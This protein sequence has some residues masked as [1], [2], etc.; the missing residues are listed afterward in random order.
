MLDKVFISGHPISP[1]IH[2]KS[3]RNEKH[4]EHHRHPHV[5]RQQKEGEMI[6]KKTTHSSSLEQFKKIKMS[7]II[8][9]SIWASDFQFFDG[10]TNVTTQ[11]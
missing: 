6:V 8:H 1:S 4:T 5:A 10:K 3:H 11:K 2:V 9:S 7:T